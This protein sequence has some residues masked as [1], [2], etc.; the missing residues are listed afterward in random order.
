MKPPT[1]APT[2]AVVERDVVHHGPARHV[3]PGTAVPD[4][5]GRPRTTAAAAPAD[6][7]PASA[8]ERERFIGASGRVRRRSVEGQP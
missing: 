8:M 6:A 2:G 7:N 3:M 4:P 5:A 1:A